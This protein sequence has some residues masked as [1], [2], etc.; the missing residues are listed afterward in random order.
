[1]L[2]EPDQPPAE[3]NPATRTP[4]WDEVEFDPATLTPLCDEAE[5]TQEI[6]ELVA[7]EA[8]RMFAVVQ[9]YG[10]RV[11]GQIVA[12]G[13]ALEDRAEVVRI[14]GHRRLSL[15]SP[16]GAVRA[17]SLRPHITARV[18][19]VNPEAQTRPSDEAV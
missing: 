5:F 16:E 13:M 6:A 7:D 9:E 12:W 3:L 1:M 17:F 18:V 14:D 19:W 4:L 8:P 15:R 10:E 2:A 11:D